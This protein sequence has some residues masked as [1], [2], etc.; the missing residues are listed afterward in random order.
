M[1]YTRSLTVTVYLYAVTAVMLLVY[2]ITF[3]SLLSQ[4]NLQLS[5]YTNSIL[6]SQSESF[7][8]QLEAINSTEEQ[9]K[10]LRHNMRYNVIVVSDMLAAGILPARWNICALSV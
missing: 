3:H 7:Q 4:Y 9:I 8:K 6:M 10:I 2:V 1:H 5:E